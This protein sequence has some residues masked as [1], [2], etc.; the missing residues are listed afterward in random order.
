MMVF[1]SKDWYL[2]FIAVVVLPFTCGEYS[3]TG[4][5]DVILLYSP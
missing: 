3:A 2:L 1:Y 5:L 4:Q